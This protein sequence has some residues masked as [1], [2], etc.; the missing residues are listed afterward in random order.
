MC[1]AIKH[2]HVLFNCTDESGAQKLPK[3]TLGFEA[4]NDTSLL[5]TICP[6]QPR[7]TSTQ[8]EVFEIPFCNEPIPK[9][10]WR[11]V[12]EHITNRSAFETCLWTH[13]QLICLTKCLPNPARGNS[14]PIE[15]SEIV[16]FLRRTKCLEANLI[17][18]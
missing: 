13:L 4:T 17:L 5:S 6:E 11:R 9:A 14:L 8:R 18:E 7:P 3:A 15:V 16:T 1:Q 12:S 2:T 10:Y